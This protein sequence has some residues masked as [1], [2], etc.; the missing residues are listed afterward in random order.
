MK[1]GGGEG[2]GGEE[3]N[4][5]NIIPVK[6]GRP[7]RRGRVGGKEERSRREGVRI[8]DAGNDIA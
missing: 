2:R 5:E 8:Y 3:R 6:E 7:R 4:G 1:A